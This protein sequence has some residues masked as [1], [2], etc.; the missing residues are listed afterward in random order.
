[1]K[2]FRNNA[3]F[4]TMKKSKLVLTGI[5]ILMCSILELVQPQRVPGTNGQTQTTNAGQDTLRH[6]NDEEP[7][8]MIL[9]ISYPVSLY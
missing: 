5:A 9:S 3:A 4:S 7:P 2:L 6:E 1:V 8:V